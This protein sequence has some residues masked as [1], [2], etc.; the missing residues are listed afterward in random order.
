MTSENRHCAR[1]CLITECAGPPHCKYGSKYGYEL[2]LEEI[3]CA[4]QAPVPGVMLTRST[5][6]TD[7]RIEPLRRASYILLTQPLPVMVVKPEQ[8][9]PPAVTF[10]I[11]AADNWYYTVHQRAGITRW[12]K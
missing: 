3:T 10:A 12:I 6:Q 11:A 9:T 2:P 5:Y 7:G 8:P 1:V 4:K